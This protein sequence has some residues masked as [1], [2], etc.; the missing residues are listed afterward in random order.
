MTDVGNRGG[1]P[2]QRDELPM[3]ELEML[4]TEP[5]PARASPSREPRR[6]TRW[7]MIAV[8]GVVLALVVAAVAAAQGGGSHE[9]LPV[10]APSTLTPATTASPTP[11]TVA[12]TA[13][14]APT[15]TVPPTTTRP[16]A[17]TER[18]VLGPGPVLGAAHGWL[19]VSFDVIAVQEGR[20]VRL[21]EA[22]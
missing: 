16:P 20:L 21:A 3:I 14:V 10:V 19:V 18:V 11:T 7:W 4:D 22:F 6:P 2:I 12:S 17:T 15:T 13:T 5:L 8:P 1:R 9:S